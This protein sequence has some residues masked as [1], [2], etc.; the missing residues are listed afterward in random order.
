M[1]G[2]ILERA[3]LFSLLG[4]ATSDDR[5]VLVAHA[6]DFVDRGS[7]S[8]EV[9]LTLLAFKVLYPNHLFLARG[10]HESKAMNKIYGFEVSRS[11]RGTRTRDTRPVLFLLVTPLRAVLSRAAVCHECC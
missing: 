1:L 6:G 2:P 3:T 7:F 8:L 10:N 11:P 9:I 5:V 4:M